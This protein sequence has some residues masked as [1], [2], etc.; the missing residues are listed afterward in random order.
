MINKIEDLKE[1][2][3]NRISINEDL[4]KYSWF[5]L[6]GP[7][8]I[9]FRPDNF[10]ELSNFFKNYNNSNNKITLIGAGSNTLIRDGG[11]KGTI[12]K[13]SSKFSYINLLENNII[14]AGAAT[15]DK[16]ISDFATDNSLTGLEFLACIPGSI[17]GA[18]KMNTGCYGYEISSILHSIKVMNFKGEI[19]VIKKEDINF[20]YRGCDLP[21]DLIILSAKFYGEQLISELVQKK[22]LELIEK[23]KFLNQ[24]KSR[25]V[26]VHLKI[27][28]TQRLGN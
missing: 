15:P 10:I 11:I 17:G 24:V 22:Q 21:N 1:K 3:G 19:S 12:I 6:G 25:L 18:I 4:S 14:E 20:Y 27:Q 28:K 26:V 13:L 23:K 16:K 9:F 5:N 8:E 7:G 2:F